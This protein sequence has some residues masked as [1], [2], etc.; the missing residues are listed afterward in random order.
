VLLS[1][2]PPITWACATPPAAVVV[3]GIFS[4]VAVIA[5]YWSTIVWNCKVQ[6]RENEIQK[7]GEEI[8]KREEQ[9]RKR[10][11]EMQ[12]RGEE[13]Q[14]RGKKYRREKRNTEERRNT[15]EKR[16]NTEE[17]IFIAK[18]KT[19]DHIFNNIILST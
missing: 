19:L 1:V 17:R 14:K 12:K 15:E 6:R 2:A 3:G 13:I 18:R 11:E 16:R 4:V 8:Q 9:M 7:R 10:G 5:T